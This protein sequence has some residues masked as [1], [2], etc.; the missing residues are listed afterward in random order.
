MVEKKRNSINDVMCVRYYCNEGLSRGSTHARAAY[1]SAGR[2]P[3]KHGGRKENDMGR[4]LAISPGRG[5]ARRRALYRP[6]CLRKPV[7]YF[8]PAVAEKINSGH[9]L[10]YG[11]W[12]VGGSMLLMLACA[13]SLRSLHA[14]REVWLA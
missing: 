3:A 6:I 8:I 2:R 5:G 4:R 14:W 13:P 7:V 10:D 12:I 1:Q 11:K 9:L